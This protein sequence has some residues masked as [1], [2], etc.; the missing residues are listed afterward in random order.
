L[1]DEL[2][3]IECYKEAGKKTRFSEITKRQ[4]SLYELMGV[5]VPGNSSL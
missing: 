5:P 4:A 2:D 3:I 1:L